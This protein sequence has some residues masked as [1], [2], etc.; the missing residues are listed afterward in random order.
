MLSELTL[1]F[2]DVILSFLFVF[3]IFSFYTFILTVLIIAKLDYKSG[4]YHFYP[5]LQF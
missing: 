2:A 5:N 3:N 1:A 4:F